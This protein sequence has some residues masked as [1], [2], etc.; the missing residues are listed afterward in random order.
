VYWTGA[1]FNDQF[2]NIDWI[3]AD[4]IRKVIS[5]EI[6]AKV[7]ADR[8]YP[9]TA[10]NS[11]EQNAR[12]EHNRALQRVMTGLVTDHTELFK[13]F[14]NNESFGRCLSDTVFALTYEALAERD[15]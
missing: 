5:E 1:V 11:D 10:R 3:D 2:G 15:A 14:S 7:A 9:N 6:P 12:L 4:K 13:Q 8:A